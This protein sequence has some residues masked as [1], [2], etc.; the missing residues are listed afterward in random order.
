MMHVR[1]YG[2]W[3]SCCI[4]GPKACPCEKEQSSS[5]AAVYAVYSQT[6]THANLC[7]CEHALGGEIAR[8]VITLERIECANTRG[9]M[10]LAPSAHPREPDLENLYRDNLKLSQN[11][12]H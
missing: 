2:G 3:C 8:R 1:A 9:N 6:R 10:S 12:A 11:M 5:T 7:N 4:L